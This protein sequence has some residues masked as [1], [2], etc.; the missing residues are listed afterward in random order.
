[1]MIDRVREIGQFDA[2]VLH[3]ACPNLRLAFGRRNPRRG[4]LAA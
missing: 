1:V 2:C 4:T 3:D